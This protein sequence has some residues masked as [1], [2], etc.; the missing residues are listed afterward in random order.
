MGWRA[1]EGKWHVAC[2]APCAL[3]LLLLS[4]SCGRIGFD[5]F[6]LSDDAGD[7]ET[8]DAAQETD[9]TSVIDASP[10]IDARLS[11]IIP[12]AGSGIWQSNSEI[13]R[14][15]TTSTS[16]RSFT[17]ASWYM[18]SDK[19]SMLLGAGVGQSEQ[20]F[21]WAGTGEGE[22]F[23]QHG[24][25][26]GDYWVNAD[27]AGVWPFLGQWVHIVVA[28]DLDKPTMAERVRFFINGEP[29]PNEVSSPEFPQGLDIYLGDTIKHTIGN[30]FSG[31]F[32][33]TGVLAET[34]LI[35]GA[36]I[37]AS[38]FV[39]MNNQNQLRSIAYTG[40]VSTDS[41]YFNYA[42]PE[43]GTNGFIGLPNWTSSN[44]STS[45]TTLPY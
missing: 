17:F 20:S 12:V 38:A 39:R 21:I 22:L 35:W 32:D 40:N 5:R 10:P 30:K 33:W 6:N 9:S 8:V 15:L 24:S 18:S 43:A 34:Y 36:S 29:R 13:E 26:A 14:T 3:V 41:V 19:G 16:T 45:T 31:G 44:L 1:D 27:V 11:T 7:V 42:L 4:S 28:V 37:D 2:A 23:F 25:A